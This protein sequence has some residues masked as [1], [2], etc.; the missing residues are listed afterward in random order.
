[1]AILKFSVN[2]YI[3]VDNLQY[4]QMNDNYYPSSVSAGVIND[5]ITT[6]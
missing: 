6:G 3:F 5:L 4:K 2:Q 1:M